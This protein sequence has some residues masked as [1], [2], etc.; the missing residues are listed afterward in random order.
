MSSVLFGPFALDLTT[1][2]LRRSG[3]TV[4]L[5]PQP[6]KLLTLLVE[7]AGEL[8]TRE[9]IRRAVWGAETYVDFDQSVNFCVRQIRTA[10]HDSAN[11]PCYLE[12]LPRRGYR[13]IAPVQQA[14]G[15][16]GPVQP[17][18]VPALP[19]RVRTAPWRRLAVASIALLIAAGAS[20][21]AY[22]LTRASTAS[23]TAN[24]S[25][26]VQLGL[27]FLNKMTNAD[28]LIAIEHFEAAARTDPPNPIALSALAEAYNQLG[29][30]FISVKPPVN[31]RL[32]ARRAASRAIEIAPNLA[33]AH[34]ALGIALLPELQWREAEASL[35]RAI[36]LKPE[37]ARAHLAYASYLVGRHRFAEAIAEARRGWE[38][39]PTSVRARHIFAW[40]LYFDR[41]YDAAIREL[42]AVLQMDRGF[43]W[44]QWRLGQVLLVAGHCDEAVRALR[45][46]VEITDRQPATLGLLAMA[47]GCT[48]DRAQAAQILDELETRSITQNVPPGAMLLGY[49]AVNDRSKAMDVLDR[50]YADRDGYDVYVSAD[51]LMDPL[52]SEPRF[53]AICQKL[54]ASPAL[55]QP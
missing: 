26:D 49:L 40:M 44:A 51:P 8:V 34:A 37:Y 46:A 12:T 2:E 52:R 33:E 5:Q 36:E 3:V 45:T 11:S 25:R 54:M 13:F 1:G 10:L 18:A 39:D 9:E 50:I 32:L 20:G 48:G 4:N 55:L 16:P 31:V 22:R 19:A 17:A 23:V 30:V 15:D 53:Q 42:R 21:N 47:E 43:A 14:A 29:G 28:T 7:R 41:Q 24:G 27:Y 38:L 6:A 35:R